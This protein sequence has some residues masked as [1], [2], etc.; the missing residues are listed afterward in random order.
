MVT[1]R[2]EMLPEK[3]SDKLRRRTQA[4][5]HQSVHCADA[6][7]DTAGCTQALG[8]GWVSRRHAYES[9]RQSE[10]MERTKG[11][12]VMAM[13]VRCS[14]QVGITDEASVWLQVSTGMKK[15]PYVFEDE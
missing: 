6:G 5:L 1:Q 15:T 2:R 10:A 3:R 14:L 7:V 8:S 12:S 13:D 9:V 11:V 4:A